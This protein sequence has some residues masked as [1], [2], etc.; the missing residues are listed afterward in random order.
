MRPQRL[1]FSVV[2][3]E[4]GSGAMLYSVN[5]SERAGK[6]AKTPSPCTQYCRGII[7]T[8]CCHHLWHCLL[9][10]LWKHC[11]GHTGANQAWGRRGSESVRL[12]EYNT[13]KQ[14]NKQSQCIC[15][16][17]VGSDIEDPVSV[18]MPNMV[19]VCES[20]EVKAW[21]C[22]SAG[23]LRSPGYGGHVSAVF[24]DKVAPSVEHPAV[25]EGHEGVSGCGGRVLCILTVCILQRGELILTQHLVHH[26]CPVA[27]A[28]QHISTQANAAKVPS[29]GIKFSP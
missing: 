20:W 10:R 14:T 16:Q 27:D 2:M 19:C 25:V 6:K 5:T 24:V 26:K 7:I 8:F 15:T 28:Q 23:W 9:L 18:F 17:S 29:E 22:V 21:C 1:L 13:N 3:K 11:T 12:K 4:R